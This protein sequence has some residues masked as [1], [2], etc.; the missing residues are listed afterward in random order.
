MKRTLLRLQWVILL[1]CSFAL[2]G[3]AQKET[4]HLDEV[5]KLKQTLGD[6]YSTTTILTVT[7]KINQADLTAMSSM[8]ALEELDISGATLLKSDGTAEVNFPEYS[9]SYAKK[10]RKISLPNGITNIGRSAFFK[11]ETI[12]E[13]VLPQGLLSIQQSAF[14]TCTKL[15][16]IN[17][18][19]T[20]KKIARNAFY[21]TW[22]LQ[23]FE[24]P[25]ALES[26][27]ENAFYNSGIRRVSINANLS[28][29]GPAVFGGCL[30]LAEFAVDPANKNFKIDAVDKA[31]Y[32]FDG[33]TLIA[34][35]SASPATTYKTPTGVT[36]LAPSAFD[37]AIHLE[38]IRLGGNIKILPKSL[39]HGCEKLTKVFVGESVDSIDVGIFEACLNLAEFHIRAVKVPRCAEYPFHILNAPR[40]AT[41]YAPAASVEDYKASP[42]FGK[43]FMEF[44]VDNDE[45]DVDPSQ[46]LVLLEENF[47][48]AT[49]Q[50][51]EWAGNANLI[52]TQGTYIRTIKSTG[53]KVMK[54][55]DNEGFG[56]VKTKE[57]NLSGNEG[58]FRVRFDLD[59]WND[60][61][62]SVWIDLVEGE[63]VLGSQ[64]ISVYLPKMGGDLRTFDIPFTRGTAKSHLVFRTDQVE[65]IA[66]IDNIKIY[67][68]TAPM[69]SYSCDKEVIDFGQC[70]Q[71][72]VPEKQ[73]INLTLKNHDKRPSI[74]LLT[75]DVGIF[76]A[77][78]EWK[79]E[80]S[81]VISISLDAS[82]KGVYKGFL[83]ISLND[84][85]VLMLPVSAV[86]IDA[87][88]PLDLDDS[89]PVTELD[90]DFEKYTTGK[91]PQG[92]K[93]VTPEG[94]RAWSVRRDAEG[95]RC[96]AINALETEG[97]VHSLLILPAIDVDQLRHHS[98]KLNLTTSQ[99]TDAKLHLVSVEK[100]TGRVTLLQDLTQKEETAWKEIE[101]PLEKLSGV[102][103]FALEYQGIN[104]V[105]EKKTTIYRVDRVRIENTEGIDHVAQTGIVF[106]RVGNAFV[107]SAAMPF[108]A[109]DVEGRRL[110]E[111]ISGEEVTLAVDENQIVLVRIA[112]E[113]LKFVAR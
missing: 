2:M 96:M 104:T 39:F 78:V 83:R 37:G 61:V 49:E 59:G 105:A 76:D 36:A 7:G 19:A 80:E 51:D 16:T 12:E 88:N 55:G 52:P 53:N 92:W 21:K 32:S 41:L 48:S 71:G 97:V 108:V 69:P 95:N 45:G 46:D 91:I 82:N 29:I 23:A 38:S 44:L 40:K 58:N 17:M 47:D 5:G 64:K 65:R 86:V 13:I 106:Q 1:V 72:R 42:V 56:I 3:Q 57:L 110:A 87:N 25:A 4:I 18:P 99:P 10:I 50:T 54:L 14:M 31:L 67:T 79:N 15:R 102:H 34:Y 66:L 26:L 43:T 75:E 84:V 70:A 60:A 107:L 63:K 9:F 85:N 24:A 6:K 103:F 94:S 101:L 62:R 73:V 68:T 30:L 28:E 20:L 77:Q 74:K 89:N 113:T 93:I 81:A 90:E 8:A 100:K 98:L 11:S 35:P 111:S 109:F 33:S 112:Q 27:G 22:E